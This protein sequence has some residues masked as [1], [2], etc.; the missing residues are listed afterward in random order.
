MTHKANTLEELYQAH[1]NT[2][3]DIQQHLG[4]LRYFAGQCDSVLELGMR[5]GV[6]TAAFLA[7][8]PVV[9][10][11]DVER[12]DDCVGQLEWLCP[13]KFKFV[14]ASSLEHSV[15]ADLI[16]FD[17]IHTYL[18]LKTELHLHAH[19]AGRYM[20][21]HDT[22]TFRW[23]GND[24]VQQS[25]PGLLAAIE[26]YLGGPSPTWKKILDLDNCCGLMVLE[27]NG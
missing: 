17:T 23:H 4:I 15:P 27:R 24:G 2:F 26:P 13:N 7:G 3:S 18:H 14:K 22:Q 11:V 20:I 6:S 8:G 25:E 5:T 1:L 9:T 10:S 21:F 19:N 16:F 12:W